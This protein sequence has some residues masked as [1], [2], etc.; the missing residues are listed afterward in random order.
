M[1]D[2]A[3]VMMNGGQWDFDEAMR[4]YDIQQQRAC[5][6]E[7]E[8]AQLKRMNERTYCAYCEYEV[9]LA[10]L[11]AREKVAAHIY[12]CENH[13]LGIRVREL[14]AEVAQLKEF[15]PCGHPVQAIGSTPY[16]GNQHSNYCGWC[17]DVE[18]ERELSQALAAE[19]LAYREKVARLQVE[20]AEERAQV[21]TWMGVTKRAQADAA[22]LREALLPL[23]DEIGTGGDLDYH[24]RTDGHAERLQAALSDTA[25]EGE[26]WN[27]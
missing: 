5:R 16:I 21:A 26:K 18:H 11:D 15:Q 7:A 2:Q 24:L 23:L 3:G 19:L 8:V 27:G 9:P 22:W 4:Q 17:A 20:I 13:P 14:S 6:A 12:E 25:E 1:D 10:E